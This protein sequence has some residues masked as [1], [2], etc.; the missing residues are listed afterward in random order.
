MSRKIKSPWTF[1][2]IQEEVPMGFLLYEA[3][4]EGRRTFNEPI[5]PSG[6]YATRL[7]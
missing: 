3:L 7:W 1:E 4:V 5:T 6:K 2:T